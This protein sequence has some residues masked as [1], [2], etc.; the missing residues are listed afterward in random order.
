MKYKCAECNILLPEK[1]F[2]A[3][4]L[5]MDIKVIHDLNHNDYTIHNIH[6]TK[7]RCNYCIKNII[8]KHLNQEKK[9]NFPNPSVE[10]LQDSDSDVGCEYYA[11]GIK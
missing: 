1:K 2:I 7:L 3:H 4:A 6:N 9:L 5:S 8:H 11:Y 10:I